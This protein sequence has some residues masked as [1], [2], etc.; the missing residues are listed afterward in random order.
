MAAFT[1]PND[2]ELRSFLGDN[3][4]EF[5]SVEGGSVNSNFSFRRDGG[6]YFLRIYEEQDAAG[7]AAERAMVATLASAGVPTPVATAHGT[8]AGKPSAVFPWVEGTMSCQRGVGPARAAAVG[9]ALGRVAVAGKEVA[10]SAGR[11]HE[12]ALRERLDRIPDSYPI[13][14]I[15]TFLDD[16]AKNRDRALPAGLVHGDL[17]RD[18]VLWAP[19]SAGTVAA[20]LDF[21]SAFRGPLA[22]DLAV[23]LLSWCYGDAFEPEL[24]RAMVRG[25]ESV[26]PLQ[27]SEKRALYTEMRFGAV[28][29]T[30]TRITDYAMRSGEGRV[31]KDW[32][33][34]LARLEA[35]DEMGQPRFDAMCGLR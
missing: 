9:A 28:R 22:Y 6:R 11:F 12:A 23:L 26:R 19:D 16:V 34:F 15:R 30:I 27:A 18:N 1:R 10:L 31:M 21:E 13:V 29:F 35:L 5:Q 3:Y 7:A 4:V 24:A 25:Y 17:F 14:R 33:R 32:R 2:E 8:L 20:L